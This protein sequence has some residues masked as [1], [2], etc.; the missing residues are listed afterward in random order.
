MLTG[1][2][3]FDR[4]HLM[5]FAACTVEFALFILRS[6]FGDEPRGAFFFPKNLLIDVEVLSR[7]GKGAAPIAQSVSQRSAA[8]NHTGVHTARVWSSIR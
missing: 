2:F 4:N 3:F 7:G 5:P 6:I 1:V 8:R